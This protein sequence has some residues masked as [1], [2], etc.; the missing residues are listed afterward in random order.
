[1]M[2]ERQ[3]LMLVIAGVAAVLGGGGGL[4]IVPAYRESHEIG[5]RIDAL[6]QKAGDLEAR[7]ADVHRLK[8]QIN[9]LRQHVSGEL[10]LIPDSADVSGL[11]RK[12]SLPVDGTSVTDQEFV[13][14]QSASGVLGDADPMQ[15]TALTVEL[16]A[17]FESIYAL[18]RAVE[19]M[20]RLVRVASVH[21][22]LEQTKQE[23]SDGGKLAAS[24][25]LEA[26]FEAE[27]R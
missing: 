20:D 17:T 11:I 10:K 8:G 9:A 12:L 16:T 19:S 22:G 5:A 24:L 1:M 15:A 3:Q 23:A 6:E 13:A 26:I 14:G 21:M 27:V 18:L 4:L 7:T 25:G 2:T